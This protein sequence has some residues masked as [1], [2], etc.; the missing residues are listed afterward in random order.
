MLNN[1]F[2]L[3]PEIFLSIINILLIGIGC[4]LSKYSLKISQIK[5]L[6]YLSSLSFIFVFSRRVLKI[7]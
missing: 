6:N 2:Y 7:V 4:F 1:I 3:L 5:K